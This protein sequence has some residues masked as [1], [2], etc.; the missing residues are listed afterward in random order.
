MSHNCHQ[1]ATCCDVV[2]GFNC[3]CDTGFTG[4]G[5]FCEGKQF[6]NNAWKRMLCVCG[7]KYLH[8]YVYVYGVAYTFFMHDCAVNQVQ[9]F[10]MC[11][12]LY[13]YL[14]APHKYSGCQS[15]F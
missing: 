3:I 11:N 15:S 13:T 4:N 5:T 8:A 14:Y 2:G 7:T 12:G 1:N 10:I 6:N 9:L